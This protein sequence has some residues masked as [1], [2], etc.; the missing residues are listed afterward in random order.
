MHEEKEADGLLEAL[1]K[2]YDAR[3]CMTFRR[4]RTKIALFVMIGLTV[5]LGI[6]LIQ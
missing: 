5:V 6:S 4:K 2:R 3:K 1:H